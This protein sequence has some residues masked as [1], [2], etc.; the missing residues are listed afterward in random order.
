MVP[1]VFYGFSWSQV[2]FILFLWFQVV[3]FMVPGWFLW[4][5]AG[6]YGSR[7]VFMIPDWFLWF[8]IGFYGFFSSQDSRLVF[9]GFRCFFL[10]IQGSSLVVHGFMLV[11]YFF[12]VPGRFFMVPGQFSWF[13]KIPG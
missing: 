2:G 10:V 12:K 6:F 1:G 11:L 7:P 4:F 8:Q 9:H 5:Q 3:L 13:F